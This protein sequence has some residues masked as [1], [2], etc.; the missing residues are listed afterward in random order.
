MQER[1]EPVNYIISYFALENP[2]YSKSSTPLCIV[3]FVLVARRQFGA[4][5]SLC[6]CGLAS[7]SKVHSPQN[8]VSQIHVLTERICQRS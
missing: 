8:K 4:T 1:R 7:R 2:Y 5:A 3:Y 6:L